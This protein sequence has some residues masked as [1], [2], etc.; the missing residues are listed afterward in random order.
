MSALRWILAFPGAAITWLLF[1]AFYALIFPMPLATY[2]SPVEWDYAFVPPLFLTP[3]VAFGVFTLIAPRCS[4]RAWVVG[5]VLF[6]L[7]CVAGTGLIMFAFAMGGGSPN[8]LLILACE[9]PGTFV[10]AGLAYACFPWKLL[11]E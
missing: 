1:P 11:E 4:R 8:P 10:G 2:D 7:L 5:V 9:L 6:S 3:I